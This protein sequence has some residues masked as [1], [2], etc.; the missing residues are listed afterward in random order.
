MPSVGVPQVSRR[1]LLAAGGALGLGALVAGCGSASTTTGS[2]DADTSTAAPASNA[3]PRAWAFEDDRGETA[4]TPKRPGT[5]VAFVGTAAALYD[6]GIECAGVFGPTKARDGGADVQAGDLDVDKVSVL[7][8]TWGEFN[9]EKYAALDPDLLVSAVY[10]KDTLWYVPEESRDEILALAPSVGLRVANVSLPEPLRRHAALAESLGADL[11]SA[12]VTAARR[13]FEQAVETLRATARARRDIRVLACSASTD[14]FYVSTPAPSAD[15]RYFKD[16]GVNLVVPERVDAGGFFQ[17]LSWENAGTY[18]ADLILLDN[19][20][21][22]LQPADLRSQPTWGRLPA[23]RAGQ[24]IG[25][26]SEPRFS[27]AGCAPNLE[28]L[29]A[30]IQQAKKVS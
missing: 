23:V 22:A 29:A 17:S 20:S 16:L 9:V 10:E 25:W 15:L 24:V 2:D 21:S 1:T 13:R 18:D 26:V 30:A 8:N 28:A 14:L 5:V 27:Y 6:Y 7:G 19:R 11:G 3:E 4:K 12:R